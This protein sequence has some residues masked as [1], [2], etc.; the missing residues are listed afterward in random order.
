MNK[1]II[2]SKRRKLANIQHDYP[3]AEIID[4]TSKATEPFVK[5]S[6]FYPLGNIPIPFSEGSVSASVE[7]VWQGLKVFEQEDV[8][9]RKFHITNRKG[10]KRTVRKFGIPKG[11]RK[12]IAGTELLGYI[13]A[14]KLIYIPTYKWVLI[15]RLEKE[16]QLLKSMIKQ[17][18][19]VL[20][21]YE[22]NGVIDN[23]QKPLSHAYLIKY[24]LEERL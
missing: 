13:D 9:E 24:F 16:V 4:V 5:F 2:A 23:P 21:D 11:H 18:D 10:L 12:G 14:R 8:D 15:N 17:K 3:Q 19:L 20:L 6:P 1:I 7:G 22:T